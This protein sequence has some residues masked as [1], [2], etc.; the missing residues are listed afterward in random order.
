MARKP[1]QKPSLVAVPPDPDR[2]FVLFST[3][4]LT[5]RSAA[6]SL[7]SLLHQLQKQP[8]ERPVSSINLDK[9]SG[10]MEILFNPLSK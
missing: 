4:A 8:G 5:A 3:A 10:K 7:E 9:E 1:V 6:V 2:C